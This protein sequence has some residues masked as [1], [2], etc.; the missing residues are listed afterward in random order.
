MPRSLP[1]D[2]LVACPYCRAYPLERSRGLEGHIKQKRMCSEARERQLERIRTSNNRQQVSPV[3]SQESSSDNDDSPQNSPSPLLDDQ[4]QTDRFTALDF[5]FDQQNPSDDSKSARSDPEQSDPEVDTH[6][7]TPAPLNPSGPYQIR[8]RD[9]ALEPLVGAHV[10]TKWE[11]MKANERERLPFFPWSSQKEFDIVNWLST[12]GLSQSAIDRFLSLPY[13][14]LRILTIQLLSI[15]QHIPR[16]S[17]V[18]YHSDRQRRCTL[19]L[20]TS[21]TTAAQSGKS[22][23]LKW[24]RLQVPAIRSSIETQWSARKLF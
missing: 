9:P 12:E 16:Y 14:S 22:S 6:V 17:I 7:Q 11:R 21:W 1:A 10:G 2:Q 24:T 18:P 5:M 20:S 15:K 3:E 8:E 13:V 23:T 19:A 4:S